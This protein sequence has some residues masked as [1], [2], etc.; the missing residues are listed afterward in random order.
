MENDDG[1]VDAATT[2]EYHEED[3]L[4]WARH[5]GGA[6]RL[7]FLVGVRQGD[8]GGVRNR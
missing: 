2:F 7:G 1:D 4:V 6:I 3:D 5:S 8:S